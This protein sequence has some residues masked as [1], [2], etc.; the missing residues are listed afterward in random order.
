M[1]NPNKNTDSE[2]WVP[3][4]LPIPPHWVFADIEDVLENISLNNIKI[5]QN[6]YLSSGKYPVID[7]GAELIGGYTNSNGKVIDSDRSV[8]IFGD[9][10]KCF[11]YVSFPFAPGADGIKVLRPRYPIDE[12]F[13]YYACRSLRLPDRGYSRHYSFLKRSKFPLPPVGEQR[14]IV[15]KIEVLYSEL[16]KGIES[17]KTAREQLKAYRQAVLKQAFEGKLTAQWREENKDK[18]ETPDQLLAR[19]KHER[20]ARYQQ[21]LADWK[22]DVNAWEMSGRPGKKRPKPRLPKP[23]SKLTDEDLVELPDLPDS[24]LWDKLGWMTC[25]AE[26]GTAAKSSESGKIPVLR[27]GNIQNA[28]F[29]WTDLVYTSDRAEIEKYLLQSGD[30]LFNR[31]NS[32]ELVGKTA[33]YRGEQPALFAGYLIRVNNIPT[34][35]HS[36]HLN[37]FLSSHVAKH[38]GNKVKTDGVNQSN[39]N[40]EKLQNY[41]FPYCSP[42]EQNEIIRILDEKLSITDQMEPDIDQELRRAEALRQS[43]LKRAFSG[44]LVEQDPND[45]PA[46]VLL[47]RI[48]AEKPAGQKPRKVKVA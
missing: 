23:L 29:D 39:I 36:Q 37:L 14:R 5:P 35:V 44:Q 47:E 32:P 30:V 17:L 26:Y 20:E 18:L 22:S 4:A 13:A 33:I 1:G 28:K 10:T 41:P 9:H 7:Q 8:I 43:I 19:I 2:D 21:K 31:T 27:M 40:G 45:E 25:G 46:S 48:R 34:V 42:P 38:H 16:D 3:V 15:A 24:W 12:K 6:N 11:K